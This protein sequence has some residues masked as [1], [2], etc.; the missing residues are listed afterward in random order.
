MAPV[1]HKVETTQFVL[2]NYSSSL[3]CPAE[4]APAPFIVWR[5]TG[6]IVQNSTSVR[7]KLDIV[8]GNKETFSCEVKNK[9]HVTKK[10]LVLLMQSEF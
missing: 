1:L 2:Y 3:W 8:K 9:D 5:K 4:G 7:Y 10:D 6:V